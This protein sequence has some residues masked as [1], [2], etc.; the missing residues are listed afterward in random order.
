[1]IRFL[2]TALIGVVLLGSVAVC[3][4]ALTGTTH[5][6]MTREAHGHAGGLGH[7]DGAPVFRIEL[8]T[9]FD[10][11]DD[12]FAVKLD[13]AVETDRI[14]M[15]AGETIVLE[16]KEDV[17]RGEA[18]SVADIPLSGETVELFIQAVP[19]GDE[20]LRACGIRVR[21]FTAEGSLCD[22]Q[23]VWSEGGGAVVAQALTVQLTPRLASGDRGLGE[24]DE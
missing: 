4:W 10:A 20:G 18:V 14:L 11:G 15:K 1:M 21:V 5:F 23:T 12:P 6:D 19:S 9:T 8:T 17:L 7:L 2:S 24:R 16:R 13:D 22:D 3:Q